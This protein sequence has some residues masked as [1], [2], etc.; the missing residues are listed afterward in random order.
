MSFIVSHR[1]DVFSFHRL[2]SLYPVT[3]TTTKGKDVY[4]CKHCGMPFSVPSTLEKHMRK[5]ISTHPNAALNQNS[6]SSGEGTLAVSNNNNS[7]LLNNSGLLGFAGLTGPNSFLNTTFMNMVN[8]SARNS[9]NS[10]LDGSLLS[11]LQNAGFLSGGNEQLLD[12][13]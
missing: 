8:S 1:P 6:N 4:R 10:K 2:S 3:S 12:T 11:S 9:P 5:C 13:S 7:E